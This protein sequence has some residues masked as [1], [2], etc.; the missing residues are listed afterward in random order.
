MFFTLIL[1]KEAFKK[2]HCLK[3]VRVVGDEE[4]DIGKALFDLK[5]K[6]VVTS[7]GIGPTHGC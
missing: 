1:A 3:E 6:V 5:D 2:G 7:G 4:N